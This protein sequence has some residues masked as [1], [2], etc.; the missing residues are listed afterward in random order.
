MENVYTGNHVC[1]ILHIAP[2]TL[3]FVDSVIEVMEESDAMAE[4]CVVLDNLATGVSL[5]CDI[6]ATV[7]VQDGPAASTYAASGSI[8]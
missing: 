1:L 5:G 2:A 6:T 3:D 4:V 7:A 8:I